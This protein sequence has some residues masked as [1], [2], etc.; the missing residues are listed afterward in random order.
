MGKLGW[1]R[2]FFF[3]LATSTKKTIQINSNDQG[4]NYTHSQRGIYTHE[5]GHMAL[6]YNI[7]LD[8]AMGWRGGLTQ[9]NINTYMFIYAAGG[10]QLCTN[11]TQ[12]RLSTPDPASIRPIAKIGP[13]GMWQDRMCHH[14]L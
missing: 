9:I 12:I 4:K 10:V 14:H 2:A 3:V 6:I 13:F 11:I 7:N 1:E 8:K 5:W